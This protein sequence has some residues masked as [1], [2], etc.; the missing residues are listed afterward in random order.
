MIAYFPQIYPDELLY[1]VFSRYFL[2]I[3]G[4]VYRSSAKNLF[5]DPSTKTD[6]EFVNQMT[7]EAKQ[8][9]CK[10]STWETIL[11]EHT[12]FPY[13]ARFLE[14][15]QRKR[16]WEALLGME[17]NY[18]N[19]LSI[20]KRKTKEKNYLRYCPIC[21]E[22]DRK[23]YGETY[24]HRKH[25]IYGVGFCMEH[26]C[27]LVESPVIRRGELRSCSGFRPAETDITDIH[28][29]IPGTPDEK[30]F[31]SYVSE[32]IDSPLSVEKEI[33]V[34]AFLNWKLS[35]TAYRSRRGEQRN[36]SLLFYGLVEK[37]H[38]QE[39]LTELWKM[40]KLLGGNRRNPLEICQLAYFLDIPI[41]ELTAP[42]V[43][44]HSPEELFDKK[45]AEMIKSGRSLNGISRELQV[46]S[47]T[48][49][50]TCARLGIT[51]KGQKAPENKEIRA[52][53]E[54]LSME[55]T[56]WEKA[57]RAYP[58]YSYTRLC[59][60]Q[61][62]RPHLQWLR[63]NDKEWTDRHWPV[64]TSH[65]EKRQDWNKVD[66]DTLPLVREA[67]RQLQGKSGERPKRIT[68]HAVEKL[69]GLPEKRIKLLPK[70]RT[71]IDTCQET[72]EEYW[73]RELIWAVHQ[74][75]REGKKVNYKQIRTLTNLTREYISSCLPLIYKTG[76]REVIEILEAME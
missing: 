3:G 42:T 29:I 6:M 66:D 8:V 12:M 4:M 50:L 10:G 71:Q 34:T 21:K 72:Q 54:R 33:P 19:L 27:R 5:T 57:L 67:I 65:K 59:Q 2:H 70:C 15:S 62:Y 76:D 30:A 40:E 55:R 7:R 32:V 52:Y 45:V 20:P 60:I 23:V 18:D 53:K 14:V 9:L 24:W 31:A 13:Y 75:K 36:L 11:M 68:A 46:S 17:G 37:C 38:F 26:G 56:I 61:E 41:K 47:R 35:G 16:A 25:Q 58:T 44:E 69:L 49:R 39:G 63:R 43:P 74:L 64:G 48:I 22:R 73:G 51:A 1:S 28:G